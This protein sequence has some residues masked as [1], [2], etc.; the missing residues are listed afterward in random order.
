MTGF[1]QSK[2]VPCVVVLLLVS[3]KTKNI[4]RPLSGEML[5]VA[6]VVSLF[7]AF[8]IISVLSL[9]GLKQTGLLWSKIPD[10]GWLGGPHPPSVGDQEFRHTAVIYVGAQ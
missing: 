6:C 7:Y 1:N 10:Q 2:N 3:Y 9:V 8:D 4:V 5:T